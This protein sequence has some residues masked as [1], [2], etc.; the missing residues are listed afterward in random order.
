MTREFAHADASVTVRAGDQLRHG[1]HPPEEGVV[2]A[3]PESREQLPGRT[4]EQHDPV[5]QSAPEP[6]LVPGDRLG[7]VPERPAAG[8]RASG[9]VRVGHDPVQGDELN[10]YD[11]HDGFRPLNEH[12]YVPAGSSGHRLGSI[13]TCGAGTEPMILSD[14]FVRLQWVK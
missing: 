10:D 8:R 14:P 4:P 11:A 7:A 12:P 1:V 9:P 3:R 5:V 13:R 6:E 2:P